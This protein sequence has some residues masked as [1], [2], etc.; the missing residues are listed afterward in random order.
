MVMLLTHSLH[1]SL[2]FSRVVWAVNIWVF[3]AKSEIVKDPIFQKLLQHLQD[4]LPKDGLTDQLDNLNLSLMDSIKRTSFQEAS[5]GGGGISSLLSFPLKK[6]TNAEIKIELGMCAL[7]P[8]QPGDKTNLR[9]HTIDKKC[10]RLHVKLSASAKDIKDEACTKLELNPDGYQLCEVMSSGEK[11]VF[12]ESD[13]SIATEMTVNGRLYVLTLDAE[14]T[15]PPLLDQNQRPVV[16]FPESESSRELAAHLTSYDWNLF[17]NIQQMEFIY[18]VFGRHKF[19]KITSNLDHLI[20]RFSE[21]QFW[22]ATEICKESNLQK[23]VKVIQKFIKIASHC[24]SFNNLNSF[25]AIVAGLMNG[26]VSRLKT[27]WEKV[28]IKLKRRFEQFEALMDPSRNHR[29]LRAYQSKLQPPVI[30]FMP[31]IV[32]GNLSN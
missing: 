6:A 29:V 15:I 18:Q 25:F 10:C 19:S 26:A 28:S 9:V 16:P 21:I 1:F 32:K 2:F 17:S 20:R 24:K 22:T 5:K 14:K 31:L 3:M 27:T 8:A 13:I 12:K 11:K 4:C 23:R 7:P 30:P